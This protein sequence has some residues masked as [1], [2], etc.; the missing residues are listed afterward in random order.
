MEPKSTPTTAEVRDIFA[1]C[2]PNFPGGEFDRWRAPH[3]T[4]AIAEAVRRDCR[5]FGR[6]FDLPH[7]LVTCFGV[8]IR[9]KWVSGIAAARKSGTIFGR[10]MSNPTMI[11]EKLEVVR[12]ALELGKRA[13]DAARLVGWSR[14]TLYRRQT[15]QAQGEM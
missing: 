8:K 13:A 14:A 15:Q 12:D 10:P 11:A 2:S 6:H 4:D 1:R 3:D 5:G 7:G 9:R